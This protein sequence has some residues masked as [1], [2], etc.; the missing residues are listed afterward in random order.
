MGN[1]I[2]SE[3]QM[4]SHRK[5][6]LFDIN[7]NMFG[8][9][10]TVKKCGGN[11]Q[12]QE[13][14]VSISGYYQFIKSKFL[15]LGDRNIRFVH[16]TEYE[17]MRFNNG[18]SETETIFRSIQTDNDIPLFKDYKT[19]RQRFNPYNNIHQNDKDLDID[20]QKLI[21]EISDLYKVSPEEIK[22]Q[23]KKYHIE[24]YGLNDV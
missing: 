8:P 20:P 7:N 3:S 24:L 10:I 5:Y 11:T 16:R 19:N 15:D 17:I 1:R 23:F 21:Q 9:S 12:R 14:Q 6:Q 13:C 2:L 22:K 18:G 4:I